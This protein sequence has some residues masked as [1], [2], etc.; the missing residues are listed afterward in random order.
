LLHQYLELFGTKPERLDLLNRSAPGF[1]RIVQDTF[2]DDAFLHLSRSTEKPNFGK[3]KNSY[4][5]EP[6]GAYIGF[7]A[8]VWDHAAN[9]RDSESYQALDF[10]EKTLDQKSTWLVRRYRRGLRWDRR[11]YRKKAQFQETFTCHDA[12]HSVVRAAWQPQFIIAKIETTD[13]HP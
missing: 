10:L 9:E 3:R 8:S 4:D 13:E 2:L 11:A 5:P 6:A 12:R 7:G 1:F